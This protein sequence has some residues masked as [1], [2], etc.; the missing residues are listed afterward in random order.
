ML[1]VF[2]SLATFPTTP[3]ET[4]A[5]D[6]WTTTFFAGGAS[7]ALGAIV[8]WTAYRGYVRNDSRPM[9]FLAVGVAFLTT[10]PFLVSYTLDIAFTATDAQV[11]LSITACHLLGLLAI[12]K[13]FNR[14]DRS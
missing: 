2:A 4:A 7:A 5:F 10:V 11:L 6:E 12:V 8:A 9:L 3:L 1:D 14:P 13:S